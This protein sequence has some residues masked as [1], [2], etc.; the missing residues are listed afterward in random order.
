MH[1]GSIGFGGMN[2]QHLAVQSA[3]RI[4]ARSLAECAPERLGAYEASLLGMAYDHRRLAA[5]AA[6][7]AGDVPILVATHAGLL[8]A[9]NQAGNAASALD[10]LHALACMQGLD[11]AHRWQHSGFATRFLGHAAASAWTDRS[12]A[13]QAQRIVLVSVQRSC[14]LDIND[15]PVEAAFLAA[16]LMAL[17]EVGHV[18]EAARRL[19]LGR[20]PSQENQIIRHGVLYG[21]SL[22]QLVRRHAEECF[23][24][25]FAC[26]ALRAS[27]ATAER[28][29]SSYA[30]FS[31][32][33]RQLLSAIVQEGFADT[34]DLR[35]DLGIYQTFGAAM[36]ALHAPVMPE[37][38]ALALTAQRAARHG[39][40]PADVLVDLAEGG[41]PPEWIADF[42]RYGALASADRR[43]ASF[44]IWPGRAEALA[45]VLD[46]IADPAARAFRRHGM[47]AALRRGGFRPAPGAGAMLLERCAIPLQRR[48]Q[49]PEAGDDETELDLLRLQA[50]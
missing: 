13:C 11:G 14:L 33:D 19:S 20:S 47:L 23:A 4:D 30:A 34:P 8:E 25:A 29:A 22:M 42:D 49:R 3:E 10:L 7:W 35:A 31:S 44:G 1:G 39:A 16:E 26:A 28:L 27:G 9:R 6:R 24:D 5:I 41:G 12:F 32:G 18:V 21:R 43:R 37:P 2:Q 45:E 15:D 46:G 48:L 50:G 17:H 36:L 40:L 38:G